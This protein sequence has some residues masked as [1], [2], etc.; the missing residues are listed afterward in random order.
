MLGPIDSDQKRGHYLDRSC[1]KTLLVMQLE[2]LGEKKGEDQR[3]PLL[4]IK[5][6]HTNR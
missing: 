3:T 4:V 6:F 2:E 1:V 5:L